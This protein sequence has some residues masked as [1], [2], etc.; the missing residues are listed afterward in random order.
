MRRFVTN[1]LK[2]AHVVHQN[3]VENSLFLCVEN[4]FRRYY[5]VRQRCTVIFVFK[6]SCR[7]LLLGF[8]T[9][10]RLFYSIFTSFGYQLLLICNKS[11]HKPILQPH[12]GFSFTFLKLFTL[13]VTIDCN[14]LFRHFLIVACYFSSIFF[15]LSCRQS[16]TK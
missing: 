6:I 10:K 3:R 15:F 5:C 7:S 8:M 1:G 14:M 11:A 13:S 2:L 12:F 9:Q 4:G 16:L